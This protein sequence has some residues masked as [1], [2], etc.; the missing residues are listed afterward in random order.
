MGMDNLPLVSPLWSL[1]MQPIPEAPGLSFDTPS[2]FSLSQLAFR[3]DHTAF[4]LSEFFFPI[5][6][7]IFQTFPPEP[8]SAIPI[9]PSQSVVNHGGPLSLLER[10]KGIGREFIQLPLEEKLNYKV[11]EP[12]GYGQ[13]FVASDDQTLDWAD[14][15]FLTTLP[16]E[17]RK[18]NF[19]PT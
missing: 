8:N 5:N 2:K 6:E 15:L 12:E 16:P 13:M 11:Q 17:N 19:W 9:L 1:I 10:M 18:M 3:G 4:T 14:L 7:G